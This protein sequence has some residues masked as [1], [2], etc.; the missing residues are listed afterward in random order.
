[1]KLGLSFQDV[2]LVPAYSELEGRGPEHVSIATDVGFARLETPIISAP[3]DTVTEIPM[4]FALSKCGAVGVH[5]RYCSKETLLYASGY[6]PIAVS[7]S[8]GTDFLKELKDASGKATVV[9]DVAHGDSKKAL[10]Y[11]EQCVKM[12]F[13]VVSANICT[14]D[15]AWRYSGVGVNVYRV[16]VGSGAAC[17][18][19]VVTGVGVPQLSAIQDIYGWSDN[20]FIISD[21][22]IASSGDI[23]KALAAGA[24]AVMCGHILAG[25]TEAPGQ[26]M[27]GHDGVQRKS[28]RGMASESALSE[29]GKDVVV[30]GVS[31]WIPET[32]PVADTIKRL[33]DGVRLGFAY[34]GASNIS[35][36]RE[37]AQ[38]VQV[39]HNGVIEGMARI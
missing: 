31:S 36:L 32:G 7:P 34:L 16:G 1:M 35:E 4:I 39:T 21:G 29:N 23:V 17:T 11:A 10:D 13:Y 27:I 20:K 8:L 9:L 33:S 14:K 38:F 2:S 5:H 15:A 18:T 37:V 28:F 22:G 25:S 26:R 6:G 19:R 30:E 24:S 12:G 3:M